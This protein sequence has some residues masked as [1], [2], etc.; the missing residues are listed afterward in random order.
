MGVAPARDRPRQRGW[1]RGW[2]DFGSPTARCKSRSFGFASPPAGRVPTAPPQMHWRTL[3]PRH[4]LV[5]EDGNSRRTDLLGFRLERDPPL[6][7]E[8]CTAADMMPTQRQRVGRGFAHM[9]RRG[10]HVDQC[11]AMVLGVSD[12]RWYYPLDDYSPAAAR[13]VSPRPR[14]NGATSRRGRARRSARGTSPQTASTPR[15]LRRSHHGDPLG[16]DGV[17]NGADVVQALLQRGKPEDRDRVGQPR[18]PLVQHDQPAERRQLAQG[19]R[20]CGLLPPQLAVATLPPSAAGRAVL[21]PSPGRRWWMSPLLTYWVFGTSTSCSRHRSRGTP[22]VPQQ[23]PA[24]TQTWPPVGTFSWPRTASRK[25]CIIDV[26]GHASSW[27]V[28][29]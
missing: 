11:G 13:R 2:F 16:A 20:R 9:L 27:L 22:P 23:P 29:R 26:N 3:G 14:R 18:S 21:S 17:E 25:L 19:A 1:R 8:R 28:V 24:G 4:L 7:G 15:R 10:R 12:T 6:V 5:V